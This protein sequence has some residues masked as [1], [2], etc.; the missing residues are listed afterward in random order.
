LLSAFSENTKKSE[1]PKLLM[2]AQDNLRGEELG[3][4]IDSAIKRLRVIEG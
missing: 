2:I 3:Y 1:F 4:V